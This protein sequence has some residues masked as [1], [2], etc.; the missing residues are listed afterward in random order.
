MGGGGKKRSF[1]IDVFRV[2][3]RGGVEISFY[4]GGFLEIYSRI[5]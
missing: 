2:M 5:R 3:Y 4:L 1:G